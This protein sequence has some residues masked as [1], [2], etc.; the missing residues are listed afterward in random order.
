MTPATTER[1]G[2]IGFSGPRTGGT[3][4]QKAVKFF[5]GSK[6]SHGF[7]T[8]FPQ[9]GRYTVLEASRV[10]QRVPLAD[11]QNDTNTLYELYALKGTSYEAITAALHQIEGGYLGERYGYLQLVYF[12]WRWLNRKV[13]G[14][15]VGREAN[16]F[17]DGKICSEVQFDYMGAVA[18]ETRALNFPSLNFGEQMID[19]H[20]FRVYAWQYGFTENTVAPQDLYLIVKDHPELFEFLESN[21]PKEAMRE[22]MAS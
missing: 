18:D 14:R 6:W 16:W 17:P 15:S 22:K 11:Y 1:I 19:F 2:A 10:V 8:T 13:L 21:P 4:F 9:E 7:I 20:V 12:M 3:F 5:T